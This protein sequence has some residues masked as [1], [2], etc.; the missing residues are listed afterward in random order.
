MKNYI[1]INPLLMEV[2]TAEEE[3]EYE[4][5]QKQLEDGELDAAALQAAVKRMEELDIKRDE[6]EPEPEPEQEP[7]QGPK[8][9][10]DA[11]GAED[12]GKKVETAD[13]FIARKSKEFAFQHLGDF[14]KEP[15]GGQL[16][17]EEREELRLRTDRTAMLVNDP[18]SVIDYQLRK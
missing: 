6:P 15:G 2:L 5:L 4:K 7:K 12:T 14:T 9:P 8:Q 18:K 10:A 13:E 11:G 3:A 17:P 16:S 1:L